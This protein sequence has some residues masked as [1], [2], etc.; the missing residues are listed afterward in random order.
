MA[1]SPSSPISASLILPQTPNN[2]DYIYRAAPKTKHVREKKNKAAHD[3]TKRKH[4]GVEAG[5]ECPPD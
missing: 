4:D 3:V 1:L 2:E 5:M